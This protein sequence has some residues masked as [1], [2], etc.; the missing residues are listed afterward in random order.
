M[1]NGTLSIYWNYDTQKAI[2]EGLAYNLYVKKSD[3][4]IYCIVPANPE[5]GFVKVGT[6]RE[7]ALRPTMLGFN[8]PCPEN[9]VVEVG[10]QVISLYNETY[11]PFT[12]YP[13][14]GSSVDSINANTLKVSVNGDVI[15]VEGAEGIVK[16]FDVNGKVVA[17]GVSGENIYV[18]V[19]GIYIVSADGQVSKILK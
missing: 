12:K 3:G 16:V 8:M 2:A 17:Q 13:V 6:G 1:K 4:S 11:S 7:V 14:T 18:P 5:T 9:N 10:V 19:K 15:S